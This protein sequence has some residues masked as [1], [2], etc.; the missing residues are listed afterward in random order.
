MFQDATLDQVPIY[1]KV[2]KYLCPQV[3]P[4]VA[5]DVNYGAIKLQSYF[6]SGVRKAISKRNAKQLSFDE[7]LQILDALPPIEGDAPSQMKSLHYILLSEI[8]T[9]STRQR[10]LWETLSKQQVMKIAERATQMAGCRDI[11]NMLRGA[12]LNIQTQE[13]SFDDFCQ[14][15]KML[16]NE[17]GVENKGSLDVKLFSTLLMRR[18]TKTAAMHLNASDPVELRKHFQFYEF[19]YKQN[20]VAFAFAP[21]ELKLM[22]GRVQ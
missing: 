22:L 9:P 11:S 17:N 7:Q 20:P 3:Q 12:L 8:L 15:F 14:L 1:A 21:N 5:N 4:G 10:D 19:M 2:V 16:A 13:F 6:Y 18:N